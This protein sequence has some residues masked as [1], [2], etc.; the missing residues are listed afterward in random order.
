[1]TVYVDD[2]RRPARVGRVEGVWS[3]LLSDLPGAE[4]QRELVAF[5]EGLGLD[6]AW[7]QNAGTPTEHFDVTEPTRQLALGAGAVPIKYGRAVAALTMAKRAR[8]S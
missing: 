8:A 3:H 2:M 4:G 1:M 6:R 7:L 5:A